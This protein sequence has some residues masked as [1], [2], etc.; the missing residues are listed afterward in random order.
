[1]TRAESIAALEQELTVL[2][3]R[4]RRVVGERARGV[5]PDLPAASYLILVAVDQ[6]GPLRAAALV[7]RFD[8]DK[9]AVSRHVKH[10]VELGLLA[11]A[12]DPDDR[13]ATLLSVTAEATRRMK[14]VVAERH[15]LVGERLAHWSATELEEFVAELARYNSALIE[16]TSP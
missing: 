2:V 4:V 1:M 16:P 12:P 3:R 15:R 10:L 8:L 11:T 7:D 9:G 14:D 6:D 5:H 13:R